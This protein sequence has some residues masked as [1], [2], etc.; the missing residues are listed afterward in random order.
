VGGLDRD[1]ACCSVGD[2]WAIWNGFIDLYAG[3]ASI[4]A[5]PEQIAN[6][7]VLGTGGR[8]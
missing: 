7:A 8:Y 4:V 5:P 1:S 6:V 2:A 3:L